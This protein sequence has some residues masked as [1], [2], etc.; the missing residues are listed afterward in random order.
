MFCQK[1]SISE[2]ASWK[3][4]GDLL[5]VVMIL[6]LLGACVSTYLVVEDGVH[7]LIE[8]TSFIITDVICFHLFTNLYYRSIKLFANNPKN[9][10]VSKYSACKIKHASQL[11]HIINYVTWG[12]LIIDIILIAFMGAHREDFANAMLVLQFLYLC[13][14]VVYKAYYL[15][16]IVVFGEETYISGINTVAYNKIDKIVEKRRVLAEQDTVIFVELFNND[17]KVG[18]DRLTI[19]DYLF[20]CNRIK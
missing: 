14:L 18:A 10:V 11:T 19:A 5:F 1:Y 2:N 3:R 20:L 4:Q 6:A 7:S 9:K 17:E 15:D 16:L 8:G 13:T 12:V